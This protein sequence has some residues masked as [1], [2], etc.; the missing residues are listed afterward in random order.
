VAFCVVGAL[1]ALLLRSHVA[2]RAGEQASTLAGD[3]TPPAAAEVLR[4]AAAEP[5]A[6]PAVAQADDAP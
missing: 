5:A 1:C 6:G 2:E 4:P 3:L